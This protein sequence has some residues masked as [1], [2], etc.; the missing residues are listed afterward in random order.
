LSRTCKPRPKWR[1]ALSDTYSF[2]SKTSA[3]SL[4]L[5]LSPG[6][7]NLHVYH[8]PCYGRA[9][10][11]CGLLLFPVLKQQV[12]KTFSSLLLSMSNLTGETLSLNWSS[13]CANTCSKICT[14][15][16]MHEYTQS[17]CMRGS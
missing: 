9:W 14:S 1:T 11:C 13:R 7:W 3:I 16:W 12:H 15:T 5:L 2:C 17:V 6:R 4:L 10:D 8:P